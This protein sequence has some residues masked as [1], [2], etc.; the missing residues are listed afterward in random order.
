MCWYCHWG[1]AKPVAT[2]YKEAVKR[3]NGDELPLE[4]G[5]A[6]IVWSDCNFD[7]AEW[8][9]E[10]FDY[11]KAQYIEANFQEIP[12]E[13]MKFEMDV[14]LWSLKELAKLPMDVRC[15]KPNMP[16]DAD[17]EDYPPTVESERI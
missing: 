2:I 10:R 13:R 5:P 12:P 3:L 11:Y 17:Y 9:I 1:W 15:I 4:F 6:H 14:V 16:D 8:C 7:R